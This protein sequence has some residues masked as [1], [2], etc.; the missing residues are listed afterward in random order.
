[1]SCA[2]LALF[3]NVTVPPTATSTDCGLTPELLIVI[4]TVDAGGFVFGGV[5]LVGGLPESPPHDHAVMP[6]VSA[7]TNVLIARTFMT[8]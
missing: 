4:V 6:S 8:A 3:M 5:G 7:P 1:M 2:S